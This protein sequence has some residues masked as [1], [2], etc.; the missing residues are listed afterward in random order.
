ML[1]LC[2][3]AKERVAWAACAALALKAQQLTT[4]EA[5]FAA[6]EQ[7]RRLYT[8]TWSDGLCNTTCL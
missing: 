2:R 7:V 5:A 8:L 4:A 3:F 1:Q 6:I